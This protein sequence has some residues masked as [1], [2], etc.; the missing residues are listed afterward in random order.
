VTRKDGSSSKAGP[1]DPARLGDPE[2]RHL[3]DRERSLSPI[4]PVTIVR[5]W[6]TPDV[7]PSVE[8]EGK[9]LPLHP[10]DPVHNAKR[11]RPAPEPQKPARPGVAFNPVG[12]LLKGT[13]KGGK[14]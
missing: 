7:P 13:K 3:A 1:R 11:P 12:T 6:L 8:L 14:R 4:E 9:L 2:V 10:V 5:R